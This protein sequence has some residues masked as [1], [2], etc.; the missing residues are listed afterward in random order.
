[1][2]F[3]LPTGRGAEPI[4]LAWAN[5]PR[6]AAIVLLRAFAA[7]PGWSASLL[8]PPAQRRVLARLLPAMTDDA[9]GRGGLLTATVEQQVIGAAC[10]WAPGYHPTPWLS[11]RYL[12]A[13][14]EI[15]R[16]AGTGSLALLGRWRAMSAADPAAEHWHLALLGVDPTWQRLGV[17]RSLVSAI[18]DRVSAAHGAAYLE[19][20]RPE[21][22]GWYA[23]AGF[24]VRSEL[25]L[26]PSRV[27]WTM[28][29]ESVSPATGPRSPDPTARSSPPD[30]K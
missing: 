17:G 26:G 15:V 4:D 18:V 25:V 30:S 5:R 10:V 29:R 8:A 16:Q 28:W 27:V 6:E 20:N 11:R 19:T 12:L 3:T 23:A 1:M 24:A 13:G 7:D 2:T 14:A 22:V 9:A 21:L